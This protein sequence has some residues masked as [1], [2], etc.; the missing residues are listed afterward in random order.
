MPAD[1]DGD[2]RVDIAVKDDSGSLAH[3][4]LRRTASAACQRRRIRVT[5]AATSH[6][7]PADYDGDG[8]RRPGGEERRRRRGTID[9]RAERLRRVRRRHSER[10]AAPRHGGARG[11]RRRRPRRPRRARRLRAVVHR[12]LCR[13]TASAVEPALRPHDGHGRRATATTTALPST[14]R[15]ASDFT[16]HGV[17]SRAMPTIDLTGNR[18]PLTPCEIVRADQRAPAVDSPRPRLLMYTDY[19]EGGRQV[20]AL[21]RHRP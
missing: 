5:A 13:R 14:T 2:G 6:A 11:L 7:V 9:L 21:P 20:R 4:L 19:D 12:R 15:S 18:G 17:R 1:Y 10:A 16:G 3:R 8:A